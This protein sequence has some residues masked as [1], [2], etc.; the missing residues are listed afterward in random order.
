MIR[1][2]VDRLD[3]P[4]ALNAAESNDLLPPRHD[5][6]VSGEVGKRFVE[7]L[8]KQIADGKYEPDRACFV[9]VPKPGLTSR[10]AALLTLD[11]RV[12]YEALVNLL[13]PALAKCLMPADVVFWP[14]E[15][16][17]PKR[18]VEFEKAPLGSKH[19][20]VVQADVAGFY[21]SMGHEVIEDDL[22]QAAGDRQVAVSIKTFLNRVMGAG[23]GVPQG[24]LPSDALATLYLQA[25]DAAMIRDGFDYWRHGDDMRVAVENISRARGAVSGLENELRGR[26]LLLNGSKMAILT[27]EQYDA[28]LTAGEASMRV[29]RAELFESK[30]ARVSTDAGQLQAAMDRAEL[31]EEWGWGLFYHQNI[32]LEKVIE[33][34]RPHLTPTDAELAEH[35]LARALDRSPG[36]PNALPKELFHFLVTRALIQLAAI[37]SPV[38]IASASTIIARFPDKT[39]TVC[40]YLQAVVRNNGAEVVGA[41]ENLLGSRLFMT[42]WQEAWLY[43]VLGLGAEHVSTATIARLR[44]SSG[45]DGIHWLP[46]VESMKVLARVRQ[47]EREV[48]TRSW[49]LAPRPFRLD[50]LEAAANM[51]SEEWARRF[52]AAARLDPVE[53][54]VASHVTTEAAPRQ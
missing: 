24:L 36:R 30:V 4:G 39:E 3:L 22:V 33:E 5:D 23:R 45:S 19:Q 6:R 46:R 10:P 38:A 34:L 32:P 28:N 31:D 9:Q 16:H 48:L 27:R 44:E 13:R 42:P 2:L 49:R 7:H 12:V 37:R 26:G 50:M 15:T 54:V 18:W 21:E 52:I 51:I 17:G 43:R 1:D 35:V 47:L 29:M 40:H 14:R 11:D 8:R 41:V 20:Y 25:V 53:R